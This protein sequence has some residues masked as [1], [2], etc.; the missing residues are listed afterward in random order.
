MIKEADLTEALQKGEIAGAGLD[1]LEKEPTNA[2]NPLLKMDRVILSP[3]VSF[4]TKES[5]ERTARMAIDEIAEYLATGHCKYIV[6]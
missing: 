6:N 5:N 4:N 1:V 2:D 3:H